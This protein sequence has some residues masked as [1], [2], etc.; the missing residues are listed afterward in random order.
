MAI[1]IRADGSVMRE[2]RVEL[3]QALFER[4]EREKVKTRRSFNA[5]L[6]EILQPALERLP[7][8]AKG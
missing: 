2:V 5:L 7:Q 1:R 4:L 3:P 8:V 6:M